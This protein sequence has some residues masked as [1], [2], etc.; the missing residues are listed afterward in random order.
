MLHLWFLIACLIQFAFFNCGFTV[1]ALK[2]CMGSGALFPVLL[3]LCSII[4]ILKSGDASKVEYYRSIVIT[5]HIARLLY[6]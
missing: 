4:P 2:K 3:K 5:S 1:V 6:V